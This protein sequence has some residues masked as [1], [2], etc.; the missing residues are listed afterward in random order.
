M[1]LKKIT[2]ITIQNWVNDFSENHAPKTV[3]NAYGYI[4]CVFKEFMPDKTFKVTLPKGKKKSFIVPT[5]EDIT[6][7]IAYFRENDTNMMYAACLAA[8]STLSR[9]E[10]CGIAGEDISGN[11]I[12]VRNTMVKDRMVL[13]SK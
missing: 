7:I 4:S 9:S 5:D 6:R 1:K 3:K 11:V 8:F 2:N 10:V 13:E 12:H